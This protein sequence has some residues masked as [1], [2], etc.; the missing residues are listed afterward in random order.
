MSTT[1]LK[2]VCII[3]TGQYLIQS[4]S[5]LQFYVPVCSFDK[6]FSFSVIR[7]ITKEYMY[8]CSEIFTRNSDFGTVQ[9]SK[10]LGWGE[11]NDFSRDV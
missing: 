5:V 10:E 7:L 2:T 1:E 6:C 4:Q 3:Y 9:L 11:N 8:I